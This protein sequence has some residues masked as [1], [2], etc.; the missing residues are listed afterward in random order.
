MFK[1]IWLTL[2]LLSL[3]AKWA[4]PWTPMWRQVMS[5]DLRTAWDVA[6]IVCARRGR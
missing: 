3:M 2:R 1:R 6:G 5:V 4:P